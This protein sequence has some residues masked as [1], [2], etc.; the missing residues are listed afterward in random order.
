MQRVVKIEVKMDIRRDLKW[1]N[2]AKSRFHS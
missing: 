2:S 1:L